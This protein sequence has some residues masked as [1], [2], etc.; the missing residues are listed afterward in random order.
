MLKARLIAR[1]AGAVRRHATQLEFATEA[2]FNTPTSR[3][4]PASRPPVNL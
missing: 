3:S 2:D 4:R 1:L